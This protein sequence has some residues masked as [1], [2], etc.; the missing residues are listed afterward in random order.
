MWK[1]LLSTAYISTYTV[2]TYHPMLHVITRELMH[3]NGINVDTRI[4][5]RENSVINVLHDRPLTQVVETS[6][7]ESDVVY[8]WSK[9]VFRSCAWFAS[10]FV[11][12]ASDGQCY[13][14]SITTRAHCDSH[15]YITEEWPLRFEHH[16][17]DPGLLSP[18]RPK[19]MMRAVRILPLSVQTSRFSFSRE[20]P[21]WDGSYL[22]CPFLSHIQ[23]FSIVFTL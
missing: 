14:E 1:E 13:M 10:S 20:L 5:E 19:N 4:Q 22:W 9:L 12:P 16:C 17:Y 15:G 7:A 8:S 6:K 23:S 11:G 21:W 2:G 18:L 3:L